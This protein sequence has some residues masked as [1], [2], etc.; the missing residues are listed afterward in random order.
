MA[1]SSSG[2]IHCI[3]K[4]RLIDL[5]VGHETATV[6]LGIRALSKA[7]FTVLVSG[8]HLRFV[9]DIPIDT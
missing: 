9:I 8:K 6:C 3:K 7:L 5:L 4:Q 2:I 1:H